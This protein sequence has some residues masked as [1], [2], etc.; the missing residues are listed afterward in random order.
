M[1][2]VSMY[3]CSRLY[4]LML[5]TP[6]TLSRPR[7]ITKVNFGGPLYFARLL[8]KCPPP[9]LVL[10]PKI[11]AAFYASDHADWKA[12]GEGLSQQLESIEAKS[13]IKNLGQLTRP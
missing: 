5:V 13:K 11:L 2:S 6:F 1:S 4:L 10:L 7:T 12:F 8:W 9:T 3:H